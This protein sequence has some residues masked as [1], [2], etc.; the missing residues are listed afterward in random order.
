M[1]RSEE[2]QQSRCGEGAWLQACEPSPGAGHPAAPSTLAVSALEPPRRLHST[3]E[4][5]SHRCRVASVERRDTAPPTHT[6]GPFH[7]S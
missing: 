5:L 1:S 2:G 7:A 4:Q 3:T 6:P